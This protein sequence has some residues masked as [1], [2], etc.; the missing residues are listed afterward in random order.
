MELVIDILGKAGEIKA[1]A[2]GEGCAMLVYPQAYAPGDVIRLSSSVP[3]YVV[4]QLEDSIAPAFGRLAAPF[5]LE[6]PFG[7][8]R[9]SYSP[10]SF[11]GN[12][13]LLTARTATEAETAQ[14]RNLALNP[15]DSHENSGLYPHATANMETRGESVFAA[16]N[17]IDGFYANEGHGPW[18]YQSWGINQ[19]PQAVIRVDFGR[20]VLVDEIAVTLR[21]DFPH[22]N[23]WKTAEIA[24]S[25]GYVQTLHFEKTASPQHFTIPAQTVEWAEMRKLIKD[26]TDPSPFPALTQLEFWGTNA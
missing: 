24:F 20:P 18:P 22:D 3:G 15:L 16:R 10:K 26:E 13:H 2:K 9:V 25:N 4:A 1:T 5:T 19:N 7:E 17:A 8:K 21:A 14:R 12:M 23:W 6:V 11:A